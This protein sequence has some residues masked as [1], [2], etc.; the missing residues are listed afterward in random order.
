[1]MTL[2]GGPLASRQIDAPGWVIGARI[3]LT[4][5]YGNDCTYWRYNEDTAVFEGMGRV[6]EN[7]T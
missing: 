5:D 2:S 1:M 3:Y 6:G 4:D 7:G